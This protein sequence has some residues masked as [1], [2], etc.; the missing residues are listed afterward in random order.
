MT[1]L[2]VRK[3]NSDDITIHNESEDTDNKMKG[4][5]PR[6]SKKGRSS[7]RR[8]AKIR[9]I[10]QAVEGILNGTSPNGTEETEENGWWKDREMIASDGVSQ[11]RLEYEWNG[12]VDSLSIVKQLGYCPGNAIHIACRVIHLQ[13]LYPQLYNLLLNQNDNDK[14]DPLALLLYPL[15]KRH[16]HSS[17]AYKNKSRKRGNQRCQQPRDHKELKN[18]KQMEKLN[19]NEAE[20]HNEKIQQKNDCNNN[21]A[22]IIY[23]PFPTI[24]WLTNPLIR[25]L[26]SQVEIQNGV[27]RM[28]SRLR[29]ADTNHMQQM[30]MAHHSYVQTRSNL[31]TEHDSIQF[32]NYNNQ[33]FSKRGIAGMTKVETVKCLHAHTAHYLGQLPTIHDKKCHSSTNLVGQWTLQEIEEMLKTKH[34]LAPSTETL[35]SSSFIQ[36]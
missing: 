10:Q 25:T 13:S 34:S 29:S 35:K 36:N 18:E 16:A 5:Q 4:T 28:E 6:Q 33:T 22:K 32:P 21:A 20:S 3:R 7:R 11:R 17:Q 31:W 12:Q 19:T 1:S 2:K 14:N 26:I 15:V 30:S 8:Q 27:S 24:Y 9:T 23:E